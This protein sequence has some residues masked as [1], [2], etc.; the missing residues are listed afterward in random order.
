MGGRNYTEKADVNVKRRRRYAGMAWIVG[1]QL[2][3]IKYE[4]IPYMSACRLRVRII[5]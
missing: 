5:T 1:F 3:K 4:V 2:V